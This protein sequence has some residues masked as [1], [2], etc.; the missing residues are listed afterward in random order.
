[1]YHR[2]IREKFHRMISTQISRIKSIM[3]YKHSYLTNHT[4]YQT[5]HILDINMN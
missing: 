3:E 5:Y 4:D 1:M 2:K